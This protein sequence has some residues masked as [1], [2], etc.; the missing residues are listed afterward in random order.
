MVVKCYGNIFCCWLRIYIFLPGLFLL[1]SVCVHVVKYGPQRYALHSHIHIVNARNS[2]RQINFH[3][4][5]TSMSLTWIVCRRSN[6]PMLWAGY[7]EVPSFWYRFSKLDLFCE[8]HTSSHYSAP[9]SASVIAWKCII[10][11][12]TDSPLVSVPGRDSNGS[13]FESRHGK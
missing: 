6:V 10:L 8:F 3:A 13:R 11:Y 4:W 1:L 7:V 2:R 12:R 5:I 9:P